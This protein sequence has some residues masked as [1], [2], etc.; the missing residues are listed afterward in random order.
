MSQS[1]AHSFVG[2]YDYISQNRT[3]SAETVA[4]F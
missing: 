4:S 3:N 2:R 1:S